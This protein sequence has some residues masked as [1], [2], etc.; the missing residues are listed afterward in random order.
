LSI[1][2]REILFKQEAPKKNLGKSGQPSLKVL[3][4]SQSYRSQAGG[5]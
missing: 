4:S 5:F 1:A 2:A 3:I